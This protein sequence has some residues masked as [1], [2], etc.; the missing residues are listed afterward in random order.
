MGKIKKGDIVGSISYQV[1]G[2]EYTTDLIAANSV[3]EYKTNYTWV[4]VLVAGFVVLVLIVV[5]IRFYNH[6][7]KHSRNRTKYII[8]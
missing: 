8:K 7:K 2:L 5:G 6:R 1:E 3:E 4:Y